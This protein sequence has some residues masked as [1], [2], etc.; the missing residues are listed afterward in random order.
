VLV[1]DAS[2]SSSD[3][4]C[5]SETPY[6]AAMEVVGSPRAPLC[7]SVAARGSRSDEELAAAFWAECGFPTAASRVWERGS[8]S[9]NARKSGFVSVRREGGVSSEGASPARD[10]VGVQA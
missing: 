5:D 6:E 9:S 4:S 10:A 7:S 8:P 3:E 1:E 2:E